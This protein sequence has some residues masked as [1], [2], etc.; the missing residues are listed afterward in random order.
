MFAYVASV[1]LHK[2]FMNALNTQN[3]SVNLEKAKNTISSVLA[4]LFFLSLLPPLHMILFWIVHF[5]KIKLSHFQIWQL[6]FISLN[7][8]YLNR[9]PK[10]F[11]HVLIVL[12][13]LEVVLIQAY[14]VD[15]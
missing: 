4:L 12:L 2:H 1:T 11:R 8:R 7:M 3:V 13:C 6:L 15:F 5:P 10:C 14:E 9:G